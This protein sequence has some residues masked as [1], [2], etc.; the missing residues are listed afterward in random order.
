MSLKKILAHTK[1]IIKKNNLFY[2]KNKG[3][4]S[5]YCDKYSN[6]LALYNILIFYKCIYLIILEEK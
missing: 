1:F 6:I 3:G 5:I 2:N 4:D